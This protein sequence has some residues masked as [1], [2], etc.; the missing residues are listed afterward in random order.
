MYSKVHAMSLSKV[1]VN[2]LPL[3]YLSDL[4]D[5]RK[6]KAAPKAG[7]I[8]LDFLFIYQVSILPSISA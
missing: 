7:L 6:K 4:S 8:S 5:M 1:I 2:F 3:S